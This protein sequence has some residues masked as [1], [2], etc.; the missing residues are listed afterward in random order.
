MRLLS[1]D[2]RKNQPDA[3]QPSADPTV[4]LEDEIIRPFP[5]H[6]WGLTWRSGGVGFRLARVPS[7]EYLRLHDTRE[8][9]ESRDI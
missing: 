4:E 8:L 7:D 9:P 6:P 5:G 2:I 3:Q 1:P